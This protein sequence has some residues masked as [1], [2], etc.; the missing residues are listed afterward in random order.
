MSSVDLEEA[1]AEIFA[2]LGTGRQVRPFSAR[3]TGFDLA[4][5]Y[6]VAARVHER[7][8]ARGERPVGRKIGFTNR[9]IWDEYGVYAPIW[10]HVYDTTLHEL[11]AVSA[12]FPLAGLAEP[13]IEPEIIFGMSAAPHAAMDDTEL[14][15]C[16][17]WIAHGFELVQSIFPGWVFAAA[18]TVA[19]YGLHGALLV[20]QRV[21]VA[22]DP[23]RWKTTLPAFGIALSCDGASMEEGSGAHVLD[24]PVAALRHLVSVLEASR[25]QQPLG[26]GEIVTTGTLTRALPVQAGQTWSTRL[27]GIDLPGACV[28]FR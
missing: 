24:G 28:Q 15:G 26:A 6:R 3:D 7:R 22:P 8:V 13:R 9:R 2:V 12:G 1:A 11:A 25:D 21:P 5:A 4:A 17:D 10:G 14:L 27:D 16:I 23:S 19:A 18:D 20:G